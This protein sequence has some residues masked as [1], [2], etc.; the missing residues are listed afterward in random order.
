M[1]AIIV[2]RQSNRRIRR[3]L[4]AVEIPRLVDDHVHRL[5]RVGHGDL[6]LTLNVRRRDFLRA[7]R[8]LVGGCNVFGNRVGER[9]SVQVVRADARDRRR[10]VVRFRQNNGIAIGNRPRRRRQR[11]GHAVR[12]QAIRIVLIVPHLRDGYGGRI[13]HV[14]QV[15]LVFRIAAGRRHAILQTR[16]NDAVLNLDVVVTHQ[17]VLRQVAEGIRA[18]IAHLLCSNTRHVHPRFRIRIPLLQLDSD[19]RSGLAR[20]QAIPRLRAGD[21]DRRRVGVRNRPCVAFVFG[22][23]NHIVFVLYSRGNRAV[24]INDGVP[25]QLAHDVVDCHTARIG[26]QACPTARPVIALRQHDGIAH[27]R[28]AIVQRHGD[29]LHAGFIRIAVIRPDLLHRHG[30]RR[31]R[32]RVGD[33]HIGIAVRRRHGSVAR[34][35]VV[36]IKVRVR[37][38]RALGHRVGDRRAVVGIRRDGDR[39]R[40]DVAAN[41]PLSFLR[42]FGCIFDSKRLI[43]ARQRHGEFARIRTETVLIAFIVPRLGDRDLLRRAAVGEHEHDLVVVNR[44]RKIRTLGRRSHPAVLALLGHSIRSRIAGNIDAFA[45]ERRRL[46]SRQ[47]KRAVCP[48]RLGR[49]GC[50]LAVQH[51]VL[52]ARHRRSALRQHEGERLIRLCF[53][54]SKRLFHNQTRIDRHGSALDDLSAART[55][56]YRCLNPHFMDANL[57]KGRQSRRIRA[58]FAGC[59]FVTADPNEVFALNLI[60]IFRIQ[61]LQRIAAVRGRNG[62]S[63]FVIHVDRIFNCQRRPNRIE[64][65]HALVCQFAVIRIVLSGMKDFGWIVDS[66]RL[67]EGLVKPSHKDVTIACRNAICHLILIAICIPFIIYGIFRRTSTAILVERPASGIDRRILTNQIIANLSQLAGVGQRNGL[68]IHINDRR[69]ISSRRHRDIA[70]IARLIIVRARL[71]NGHGSTNRNAINGVPGFFANHIFEGFAIPCRDDGAFYLRFAFH[72]G[73]VEVEGLARA[74]QSRALAHFLHQRQAAG[75]NGVRDRDG[76]CALRNCHSL[77]RRIGDVI[78]RGILLRNGHLRA[79]REPRKGISVGDISA[80]ARVSKALSVRVPRCN[81]RAGMIVSF[82]RIG[83]IQGKRFRFGKRITLSELLFDGQVANHLVIIELYRAVVGFPT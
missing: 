40:P 17:L 43:I 36:F 50:T 59:I 2:Q 51:D 82:D 78:T 4:D 41:S 31:R 56:S 16:L 30:G 70:G 5:E 18:P 52:R 60:L 38:R 76:L 24:R 61:T 19:L 34:H 8:R 13:H 39:R 10:P 46:A 22:V 42:A 15:I 28:V 21:F 54:L 11:N 1:F 75:R 65:L 20:C 74:R 69:C 58:I 14:G 23:G 25:V 79:Y 3:Q 67:R 62:V 26:R 12:P 71:R 47:S 32:M 49:N 48:G 35:C 37:L 6:N 44:Q 63:L 64:R 73:V 81:N 68:T 29:A 57:C 9:I 83:I 55:R 45:R 7:D 72:I 53:A 80:V 77:I 66:A 27:L 33:C